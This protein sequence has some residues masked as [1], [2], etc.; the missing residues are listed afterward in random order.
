MHGSPSIRRQCEN[1]RGP[2]EQC[3]LPA[4]DV[5]DVVPLARGGHDTLENV[6][7]VCTL[8]HAEAHGEVVHCEHRKYADRLEV[9]LSKARTHHAPYDEQ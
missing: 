2:C 6:R 4:R 1:A 8:C 7:Y 5:H 3:G 9:A